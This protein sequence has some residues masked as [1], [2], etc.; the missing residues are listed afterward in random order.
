[1]PLAAIAK[2]IVFLVAIAC[3]ILVLV[4][5]LIPARYAPNDNGKFVK[6]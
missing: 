2:K 3:T 1:M 6:K 4:N 5:G